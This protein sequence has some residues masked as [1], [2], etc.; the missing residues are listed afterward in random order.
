VKYV[1]VPLFIAHGKDNLLHPL[2][3]ANG[4]YEAANEPKELYIINGKHNDFMY[5]EHEVFQ[6]LNE[7]LKAFFNGILT[8]KEEDSKV[9]Q[10]QR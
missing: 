7:R 9:T 10:L 3:E 4:L 6:D 2:D 5:H 8:K 1:T